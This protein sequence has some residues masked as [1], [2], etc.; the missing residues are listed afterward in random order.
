MKGVNPLNKKSNIITVVDEIKT[1]IS[2]D[3]SR[4]I[5]KN[6]AFYILLDLT[7]RTVWSKTTRITS[8]VGWA[9][10]GWNLPPSCKSRNRLLV[11][12]PQF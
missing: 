7:N 6:S 9:G 8:G 10:Q 11:K 5:Y 3:F 1:C 12:N 4:K 2:I